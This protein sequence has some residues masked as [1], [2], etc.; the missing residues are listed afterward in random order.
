VLIGAAA[1]FLGLVGGVLGGYY[2]LHAY[3]RSDVFRAM[4]ENKV[5]TALHADASFLPLHWS[6]SSVHSNGL[7]ATGR[8]GNPVRQLVLEQVRADLRLGGIF[9]GVWSVPEITVQR[10]RGEIAAA[11]PAPPASDSTASPPAEAP[12]FPAS[13]LP[14]RAVIDRIFIEDANLTWKPQDSPPATLERLKVEMRPHVNA[15]DI[16][17]EGGQFHLAG[18]PSATVAHCK[19]RYTPGAIF[20]TTAELQPANQGR[21]LLSGEVATDSTQALKLTADIRGV[22]ISNLLEGDW[23]K[24]FSGFLDGTLF[25][26]GRIDQPGS[27]QMRGSLE[28]KDGRIEALPILN[29]IASLTKT[30]DLRS[31]RLHEATAK[32]R[33]KGDF[34]EVTSLELHSQGLARVTGGFTMRGDRLEGAF[35]LGTHPRTIKLLPG[36]REN[37]FTEERDGYVWTDLRVTGPVDA[38]TEDL[39]PRLQAAALKKVQDTA[40]STVQDVIDAVESLVP[41]FLPPKRD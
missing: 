1:V 37:V 29:D 3:L 32:V 2:W 36:A 24:R 41:A 33:W 7:N 18:W 17:G 15:W 25:W 23:L 35:K 9:E 12:A 11:V 38:L 34:V 22:A 13:W 30:Q 14:R 4:L 6:G 5:S 26:E 28:L 10:L 8:P 40:T 39:T 20:V 21:V 31:M 27:L 16:V 19:L